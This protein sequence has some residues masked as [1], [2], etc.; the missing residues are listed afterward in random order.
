ME[1]G[2]V[3]PGGGGDAAVAVSGL[4]SAHIV[5]I[6]T[7][8]EA[9]LRLQPLHLVE[10]GPGVITIVTDSQALPG[11]RRCVQDPS[12]RDLT[13][14]PSRVAAGK[15]SST[16]PLGKWDSHRN[17]PGCPQVSLQRLEDGEDEHRGT[18]MVHQR[19]LR[20]HSLERSEEAHGKVGLKYTSRGTLLAVRCRATLLLR[21]PKAHSRMSGLQPLR[22]A[23]IP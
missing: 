16:S 20:A 3:L 23:S 15:C 10:T 7:K 22:C 2:I 17:F 1:P 12:S 9:E 18:L 6:R 11:A 21:M 8:Q 5:A 19:L 14:L 4:Q 13:A